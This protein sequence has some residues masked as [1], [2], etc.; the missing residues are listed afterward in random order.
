MKCNELETF[1]ND[2]LNIR[3]FND[4]CPQ[5]L[6]VEGKTKVNKVVTAVS[7]SVQLF[8]RAIEENADMII[9]HHGILWNKESQIVRGSYKKRLKLLLQNDI[10]LLAYHLPLDK[11]PVIGNNALA[12]KEF[13]L[14]DISEF[15]EVGIMGRIDECS[16]DVFSKLVHSVYK[17][18]PLVFSYGPD[19]I[20]SVGIC[21]GAAQ[22]DITLAVEQGLDVFV[23]GE[24]SES[25]MHLAREG[26]IHF[27]SA[28]HYATEKFGIKALGGIIAD[29]F[30]LDVKFIDIPNPV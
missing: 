2:Y 28:G 24:V 12:A 10:N 15:G 19:R 5:G 25:I 8:E 3:D 7:V 6:Q 4:Y 11:H 13:G 14:K 18:D 20:T 1:V 27:F 9:V 21:S 23:T 22:R 30:G 17:V 29:T 26:Q 16:F